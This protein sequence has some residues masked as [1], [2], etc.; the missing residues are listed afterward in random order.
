M[1]RLAPLLLASLLLGACASFGAN[2]GEGT[3]TGT[4]V[5]SPCR[6]VERVGDPPCPPRPGLQVRFT[7]V[8]GGAAVT[9]VTDSTG[10]YLVRLPAGEYDASASGGILRPPPSRVVVRAGAT[11][12][13]NFSLDSGIR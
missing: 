3:V 4:V 7:P 10:I 1:T 12:T 8:A 2:A 11:V 13:L 5:I 6:P 9:A